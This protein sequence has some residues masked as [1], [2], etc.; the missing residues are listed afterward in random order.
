MINV[1]NVENENVEMINVGNVE[2][3]ID[4]LMHKMQVIK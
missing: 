4:R 3:K 2:M 1:G